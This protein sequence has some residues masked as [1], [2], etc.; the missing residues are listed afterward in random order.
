MNT[1]TRPSPLLNEHEAADLLNLS[2][3]TLRQWRL[4]GR[5]PGYVKLQAAVRYSQS[6]LADFIESGR[7]GSTAGSP[8]SAKDFK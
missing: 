6:D 3:K 7:R 8:V 5:G 2:V 4:T 1:E